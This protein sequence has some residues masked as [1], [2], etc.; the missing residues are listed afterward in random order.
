MKLMI[1]LTHNSLKIKKLC[2][3]AP[4]RLIFFYRTIE[5]ISNNNTPLNFCKCLII[6]CL[7]NNNK[8]LQLF[9]NKNFASL[10]LS[11]SVASAK[12][13]FAFKLFLTDY[14]NNKVPKNLYYF[15]SIPSHHSAFTIS[16]GGHHGSDTFFEGL[17]YAATG[18]S[19]CTNTP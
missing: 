11:E 1:S 7:K 9:D 2:A 13:Y 5:C 8:L 14:C 18:G 10:C 6:N 16:N 4:L 12:D 15:L 17:I 3:F 19:S